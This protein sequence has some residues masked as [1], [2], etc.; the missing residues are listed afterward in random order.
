MIAGLGLPLLP[1]ILVQHLRARS[2]WEK[3]LAPQLSAVDAR[4]RTDEAK[5]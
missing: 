5:S 1:F 3:Q 2:V 4:L